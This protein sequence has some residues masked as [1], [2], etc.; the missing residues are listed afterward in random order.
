[1]T[2]YLDNIVYSLQPAGGISV[3]WYELSKRWLQ[4][5]ANVFFIERANANNLFRK[6]LIIPSKLIIPDHKLPIILSRY[7]PAHFKSKERCIFQS[8]YYRTTN[9][10]RALSVVTVHDFTYEKM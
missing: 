9:N 2:I 6:E 1:M 8:S 5:A 4:S 7:L 3:Y 10:K